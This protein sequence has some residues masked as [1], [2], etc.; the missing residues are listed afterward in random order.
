M[1]SSSTWSG[2]G[3]DPFSV[4]FL[5]SLSLGLIRFKVAL[6]TLIAT[7]ATRLFIFP[8]EMTNALKMSLKGVLESGNS[9]SSVSSAASAPF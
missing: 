3:F 2:L 8:L 9:K 5:G 4:P 1:L 6:E 7:E